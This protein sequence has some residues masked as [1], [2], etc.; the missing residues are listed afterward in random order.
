MI[1]RKKKKEKKKKKG[2]VLT[3]AYSMHLSLCFLTASD[4]LLLVHKVIATVSR[5]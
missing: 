2:Q 3:L 1:K 4:T 5:K